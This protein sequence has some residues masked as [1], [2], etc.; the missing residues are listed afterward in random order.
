MKTIGIIGGMSWESSIEYYRLINQLVKQKLGGLASAK[1]VM[2][3]L[4]FEEIVACQKA[5]DWNKAS[6]ILESTAKGL[7]T[8]GADFVLLCTNTMHKVADNIQNAIGI[9]FIH[10]AD[11]TAEKVLAQ[12]IKKVALLGTKYTMEQEFYTKRLT[13]H[14]L[15]VLIPEEA[16]RKIVNDVIFDELCKGKV[17]ENSRQE[18]K[19]IIA[20]LADN[21]AEGVILGCTEISLLVKPEDSQIPVFDTTEIHAQKAVE[22]ALS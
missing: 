15:D 4:N 12:G 9:P 11:V 5:A 1:I 17:V 21:G 14:G 3:S 16:D 20:E 6:S 8:N 10:I 18:Y 2:N 13:S 22:L 7:E 19:R